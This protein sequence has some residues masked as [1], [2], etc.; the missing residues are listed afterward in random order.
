MLFIMKHYY[1]FPIIFCFLAWLSGATNTAQAQNETI[2]FFQ[3][4]TWFNVIAKA[5]E[6]QKLIFVDVY[7][8]YCPPCKIMDKEVFCHKTVAGFY[9]EYFINYKVNL[10][11]R[12]NDYFQQLYNITELPALLYFSADGKTIL[13]KVT[14]CK[15]P[16]EFLVL[17]QNL[18][19][20]RSVYRFAN[21]DPHAARFAEVRDQYRKGIRYPTLLKEYA[22]LAQKYNEPFNAVVNEYLIKQENRTRTDENRKFIYDFALTLDN[23]A[24]DFLVKDIYYF[25]QTYGSAEINSKVKAAIFNGVLTATKQNDTNFFKHVDEL[26]KKAS[27]PDR[28]EFE[29]EIKSLYYQGTNDWNTYAKFTYNFLNNNNVS[30]P[31]LLNEVCTKFALHVSNKK[32]LKVATKW[33]KKAIHIENEYYNNFTYASLLLKL[34]QNTKALAAAKNA[35][36]VAKLRGID[37]EQASELIDQI[38][39]KQY[40]NSMHNNNP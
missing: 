26:I 1:T 4:D 25:K 3:S 35:I 40:R 33:I 10:S 20:S 29:F 34:G 24:I 14:G 32:M 7:A 30:D 2:G 9:N 17:G 15:T 31:A 22:Y 5:Q 36:Y 8:D 6:E 21:A 18:A 37:Y 13:Q 19:G 39:S 23:L 11:D 38:E 28:A 27:L 12:N 16:A